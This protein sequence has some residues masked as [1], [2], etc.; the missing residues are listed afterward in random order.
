[1]SLVGLDDCAARALIGHKRVLST[2]QPKIMNF[3]DIC[4]MN[5]HPIASSGGVVDSCLAYC[6]LAP[7]LIILCGYGAFLRVVTF[8]LE[9][10]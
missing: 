7:Y 5:F 4:C 1:M 6:C 2:A 10:F 8:V 9:E 3:P